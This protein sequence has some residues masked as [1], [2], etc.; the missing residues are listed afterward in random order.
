M[1]VRENK[2]K[3]ERGSGWL[4]SLVAVG[5]TRSGSPILSSDFLTVP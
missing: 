4:S 5:E 1:S 3:A 2:L